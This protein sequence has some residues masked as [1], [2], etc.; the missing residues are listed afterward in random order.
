MAR[1]AA[2]LDMDLYLF[3]RRRL[4]PHRSSAQGLAT[5]RH[6]AAEASTVRVVSVMTGRRIVVVGP[7]NSLAALGIL[8]DSAACLVNGR[9]SC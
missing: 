4:Y 1:E 7:M 6:G 3:I 9:S 5:S 8:P 2:Q